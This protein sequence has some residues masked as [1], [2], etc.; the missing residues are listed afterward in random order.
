MQHL[1]M[2]VSGAVV[3]ATSLARAALP[4]R[5]V[6]LLTAAL[7]GRD[8]VPGAG[9]PKGSGTARVTLDLDRGEVCFDLAVAGI[10]PATAARIQEGPGGGEGRGIITLMPPTGGSSSGCVSAARDDLSALLGDPERY[11]VAVR[12]ADFPDGALRGQ[13]SR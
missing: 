6:G 7:T 13:L 4:E 1:T 3:L 5:P 9:D 12:T 11:Y 10:A 2:F 8:E